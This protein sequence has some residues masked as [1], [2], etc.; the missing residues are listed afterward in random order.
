M[1]RPQVSRRKPDASL[2]QN[3]NTTVDQSFGAKLKYLRAQHKIS[4][5]ELSRKSGVANTTISLIEKGKISPSLSSIKRI[6]DALRISLADFFSDNLTSSDQ[7]FY[8]AKE[9]MPLTSGKSI[10]IFQV[11]KTQANR[12]LQMLVGRYEPGADTGAEML[13]HEGEEVGFISKGKF[14]I[15]VGEKVQIL[16]AGDAYYF[17]SDIPH[18]FRNI[19]KSTGEI[20]SA[21]TPASV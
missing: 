8:A 4:Q 10:S 16:N 13:I 5:R 14:E 21:N 3:A 11:G 1:S 7:F 6:L 17:P 12:K 19:G 2:S 15:T 20:I 18:R 9:L